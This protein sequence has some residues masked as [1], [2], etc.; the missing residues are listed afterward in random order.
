MLNRYKHLIVPSLSSMKRHEK[1]FEAI[2]HKFGLQK[3][4]VIE[5]VNDLL[6]TIFDIDHLRHRNP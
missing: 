1:R 5:S 6:M 3:R 2:S 4:A